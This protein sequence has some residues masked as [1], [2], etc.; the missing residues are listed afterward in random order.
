[1]IAQLEQLKKQDYEKALAYFMDI[2]SWEYIY[3]PEEEDRVLIVLDN[4]VYYKECFQ[5]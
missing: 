2:L 5:L 3:L 4:Q 1:M